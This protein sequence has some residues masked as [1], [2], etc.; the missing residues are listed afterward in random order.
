M[1]CPKQEGRVRRAL[2]RFE[3]LEALGR[4]QV[5]YADESGFCL[6]PPVPYLWQKKGQTVGLP[7]SAH[8]QRF[9]VL[10]IL[11]PGDNRLWYRATT[12]PVRSEQVIEA[13]ES[14]LPELTCPSVLVL[15]NA[16]V[17]RSHAMRERL[18]EWR[19]R[20]L[21]LLFLPPYRPELNRIE[22]L[23]RQVKY[24]WLGLDAYRSFSF[25][26]QSVRSVLDNVGGRYRISFG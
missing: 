6:L 13:I 11:R 10:G 1:P 12:E 14:L 16:G 19:R 23:W 4:C 26:C 18:G 2:A 22:V 21:R 3:R 25:L 20:G 24:R 17:H 7:S 5:L 9:N 8:G 15:D